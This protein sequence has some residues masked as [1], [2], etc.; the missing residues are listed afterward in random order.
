MAYKIERTENSL[1]IEDGFQANRIIPTFI[2]VSV[3]VGIQSLFAPLYVVV[4]VIAV[5]GYFLVLFRT[6]ITSIRF[7]PNG[8]EV[9]HRERPFRAKQFSRPEFR[10]QR[11]ASGR[12]QLF[13]VSGHD[14]TSVF[15][16]FGPTTFDSAIGL[17]NFFAHHGVDLQ[18]ASKEEYRSFLR[19]KMKK[20]PK[21]EPVW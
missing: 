17:Q 11:I 16:D 15:V 18:E 21:S 8:P 10:T 5:L 13:I 3:I 7:G 9:S 2:V 19:A 12:S 4:L 14:A 6:E 1:T 20:H